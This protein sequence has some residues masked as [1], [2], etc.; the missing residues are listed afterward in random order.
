MAGPSA[1]ILAAAL[2]RL[3]VE[4]I[5]PIVL[6]QCVLAAPA[7]WALAPGR[8]PRPVQW[9]WTLPTLVW[10]DP[11]WW[12]GRVLMCLNVAVA[13]AIGLLCSFSW[14]ACARDR[15]CIGHAV[16]AEVMAGLVHRVYACV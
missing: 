15:R 9:P 6:V 13:Y 5:G 2:A 1:W 14:S 16:H 4:L 8:A 3:V 7:C 11:S 10:S 12:H